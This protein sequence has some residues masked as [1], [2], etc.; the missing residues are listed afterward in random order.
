MQQKV[1]HEMGEL[2]QT[3]IGFTTARCYVDQFVAFKVHN[4]YICQCFTFHYVEKVG[5][6]DN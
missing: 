5:I 6:I 4:K 3:D 2:D 1:S